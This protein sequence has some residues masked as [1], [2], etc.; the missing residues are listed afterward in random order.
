MLKQLKSHI[1][2]NNAVLIVAL[3]ITGT[4]VWGTIEAIQQN[5]TLQQQ[6]DTLAQENSFYDL[7]NQALA[8]QQR[9]YKSSEYLELA[10]RESLNK[11]VSGEKVLILPPNTVA[12]KP[13]EP[14]DGSGQAIA[15][16][17]NFEQWMYFLFADKTAK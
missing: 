10:A 14:I 12:S 11:T 7:Q 1:T 6:V 3:C 9:Y 2:L 15:Q 4:W 5:F 17:S 8:F 13:P 16:R